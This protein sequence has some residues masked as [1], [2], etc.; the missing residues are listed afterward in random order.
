MRQILAVALLL[1]LVSPSWGEARPIRFSTLPGDASVEEVTG[2]VPRPIRPVDGVY[3]WEADVSSA[4]DIRITHPR[5]DEMRMTVTWNPDKQRWETADHRDLRPVISLA[6]T[7]FLS[8]SP[9]DFVAWRVSDGTETTQGGQLHQIRFSNGETVGVVPLRRDGDGRVTLP[10]AYRPAAVVVTDGREDDPWF[11]P[12]LRLFKDGEL[13]ATGDRFPAEPIVMR[14]LYG[15]LSYGN[16]RVALGAG[17]AVAAVVLGAVVWPRRRRQQAERRHRESIVDEVVARTAT[18][19]RGTLPPL[20]G[21]CVTTDHGRVSQIVGLIGEGGMGAVFEAAPLEPQDPTDERWAVKVLFN[22]DD[23]T[24]ESRARFEREVAVCSRLTHPGLVKVLDWGLYKATRDGKAATWRFMV[25]E[26]IEGRELR[27]FMREGT[28]PTPDALRW[29]AEA[30]RAL[31]T[32][33]AA[34][35]IHRDLKPSN[36]MITRSGHVKITD[37]GIARVIDRTRL[38]RTGVTMGSPAYMSPEHVDAHR[39]GPA[40]DIYSLGVILYE[41]LSGHLPFDAED[42]WGLI[43]KTLTQDPEPLSARRPDLPAALTAMVMR[44]VTRDLAVRYA[45]TSEVLAALEQVGT[46]GEAAG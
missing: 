41:M 24:D 18:L 16:V 35:V 7:F 12:Q 37:F 15:P 38:T 10:N 42:S 46:P 39:V 14:P 5:M 27:G 6:K 22:D 25:M 20:L 31:R 44:M 28:I 29:T 26:R 9:P 8:V 2:G 23:D 21:Q 36:I 43:T 1:L 33:H 45:S 34:G 40:S 17:G 13:D 19:E 3:Q 4:H 11:E 32:A 30:L